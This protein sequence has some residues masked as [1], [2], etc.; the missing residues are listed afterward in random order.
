MI[1]I[2][3][4]LFMPLA[5]SVGRRPVILGSGLIPIGGA[6]WAGHNTSLDSHLGARCIQAVG[7]GRVESLLSFIIQGIVFYHQRNAVISAAA[8]E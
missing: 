2:V 8:K 6:V 7:S 1:G 3:Y 4:F 5:I